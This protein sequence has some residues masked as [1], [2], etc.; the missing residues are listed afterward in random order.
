MQGGDG[1]DPDVEVEGAEGG[2]GDAGEGDR[3]E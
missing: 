2:G 3:G 1:T